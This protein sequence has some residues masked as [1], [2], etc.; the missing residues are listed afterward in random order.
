MKG[1]R[2]S[3]KT[4]Y[5]I[6]SAAAL[7]AGAISFAYASGPVVQTSMLSGTTVSVVAPGTKVKVGDVL[8]MVDSLVG[9]VPA[10]RATADGT[11]KEVNVTK[12]QKIV[13]NQQVAVIAD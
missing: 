11:V 9:P 4:R 6:M 5:K 3:M 1:S 13:Q 10:A 7:L 2:V 12:G 8:V